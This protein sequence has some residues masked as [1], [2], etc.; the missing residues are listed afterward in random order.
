M[1]YVYCCM[2]IATAK[3]QHLA[4]QG[5]IIVIG[6]G[7]SGLSCALCLQD[8]GYAVRILSDIPTEQTTSSVAAAIWYPYNA[9][10]R[11]R[12]LRWGKVSYDVLQSLQ[13]DPES[14][15]GSM[16]LFEPFTEPVP[17]PWWRPA[18]AEFRRLR[19]EELPQGY[20][21]GYA[22]RV[23]L[24]ETPL[25]LPY[26]QRRFLAAGGSIA[27]KRVE[28]FRDLAGQAHTVI[29]CSGLGAKQL[30]GDASLYPIRGQILKVP[31]PQQ[32][33]AWIEE[34]GPLALSYIV[35][36][37][38]A[39]VLGGSA[40]EGDSNLQPQAEQA[41]AIL[42]RCQQLEPSLQAL[43]LDQP[44]VQQMV[45]LRPGRSQ[46]RLEPEQQ[47]GLTIIHNYGHGG[48]GFTLSWGCA[49]EVTRLVAALHQPQQA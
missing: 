10:P 43:R 25:Y 48:A 7:V 8:Q 11:D 9:Q 44:E 22:A 28:A 24:I 23:P 19:P 1:R 49:E 15:V 38:D 36:R 18:V 16:E 13:N 4:K 14:G 31:A 40:Q 5:P 46:V 27:Y 35:P 12:M 2:E 21:D 29:N 45:G 6:A 41:A 47:D 39:C 37:R 33:R 32:Q 26:L 17:E 34:H 3:P 42:Q 30:A 20:V